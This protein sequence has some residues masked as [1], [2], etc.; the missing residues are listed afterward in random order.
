MPQPAS[1]VGDILTVEWGTEQIGRRPALAALVMELIAICAHTD[2]TMAEI[3][4]ICLKS[5]KQNGLAMYFAA[6]SAEA[7]NA[8]VQAAAENSLPRRDLRIFN[9]VRK[10]FKPTKDRRNEFVHHIWATSPQLPDGLLLVDPRDELA[11][12]VGLEESTKRARRSTAPFSFEALL[13]KTPYYSKTDLEREVRDANNR[14]VLVSL[15]SKMLRE[16]GTQRVQTRTRL[17]SLLPPEK[18]SGTQPR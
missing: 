9:R 11:V 3:L 4:S 14:A 16:K 10:V 5:G 15:V 17:I 6:T 12:R 2:I 13:A 18:P 8:M 1:T 7:R